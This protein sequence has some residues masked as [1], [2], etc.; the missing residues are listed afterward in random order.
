MIPIDGK[1]VNILPGSNGRGLQFKQQTHFEI[2]ISDFPKDKEVTKELII[3]IYHGLQD[4]RDAGAESIHVY[5]PHPVSKYR[6]GDTICWL[7]PKCCS[8]YFGKDEIAFNI[9]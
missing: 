8:F 7:A 4:L 9:E 1:I 6:T 3:E 2:I 5:K